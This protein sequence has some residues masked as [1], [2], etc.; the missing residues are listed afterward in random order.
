[1]LVINKKRLFVGLLSA[2]FLNACNEMEQTKPAVQKVEKYTA[3]SVLLSGKTQNGSSVEAVDEMQHVIASAAV[4][5]GRYKLE[6]PAQTKLP[7]VLRSG[8]LVSV[9]VDTELTRYDINDLTTKIAAAAKSLGGYTR[10]NMTLAASNSV[11]VPD[12]NKTSTGFRGDPTSQ[13][14]GWH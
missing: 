10:K 1:M 4:E 2:L 11:N 7:I 6:I 3:T 5:N 8:E 12:A 13:Y 9:V 14:G